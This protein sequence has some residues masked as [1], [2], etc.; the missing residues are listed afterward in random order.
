[1]WI[2]YG[3]AIFKVWPNKRPEWLTQLD[4]CTLLSRGLI[5]K[6]SYDLSQ[7][8]RKFIVRS[9]YDSDLQ[10][11]KEFSWKY[12]KLIY[13]H[14][15]RW[16]YDFASELYPRKAENY[17]PVSLTSQIC[18]IVESM[19]RHKLVSHLDK[20]NLIQDSQHGFHKRYS[21]AS[22]LLTFLE[23]VTWWAFNFKTWRLYWTL[24]KALSGQV[25]INCINRH[26][27]INAWRDLFKLTGRQFSACDLLPFL[28]SGVIFA[29]LQSCETWPVSTYFQKVIANCSRK[30][31][32][33]TDALQKSW[34]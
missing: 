26:F 22:N 27:I 23:K 29:V 15:L 3:W 18:K 24:S 9:T 4:S 31:Y 19:L 11:V 33:T 5:Y 7:D 21:C 17:R 34:R 12:C 28:N 8:Y 6:I 10:R 16:S 2:L 32:F 20:H 25:K 13:E 1:M 30:C 14:N